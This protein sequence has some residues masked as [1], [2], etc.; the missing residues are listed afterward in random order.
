MILDN[1]KTALSK[2]TL[3]IISQGWDYNE[4]VVLL[5]CFFFFSASCPS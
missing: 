1:I 4:G 5:F 3:Q 2:V